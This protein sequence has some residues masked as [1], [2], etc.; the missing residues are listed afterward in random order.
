MTEPTI[1]TNGYARQQVTR[2]AFGWP[3][4]GNIGSQNY[5]GTQWLVWTAVGGPFDQ[6]ITRVA[7]FD[8]ATADPSNPVMSLS[9]PL[10]AP[11]TIDTTTDAADSTFQYRLYL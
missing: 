9:E 1:G 4:F 7:L 5:I 3:D 2:D 11:L 8:T 10:N 6:A